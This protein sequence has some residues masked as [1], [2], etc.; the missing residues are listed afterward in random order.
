MSMQIQAQ[1]SLKPFNSFGVDVQA[2]LFAEAHIDAD[3]REALVYGLEHDVPVLVIG[4]GSSHNFSAFF[5]GTDVAT[6][7]AAGFSVNYTE[8]RDQAAAEIGNADVAVI[9]VNRQFFDTPEYRKALFEFANFVGRH[10]DL[11]GSQLLVLITRLRDTSAQF[12]PTMPSERQVTL[13]ISDS[14]AVV[15]RGTL[16]LQ[17]HGF[18]HVAIA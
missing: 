14:A 11:V 9:S 7:A 5:G 3:V 10:F 8:D 12:A 6:L 15:G 1:V 4:G 16:Q 2:R 17:D 13:N 18:L